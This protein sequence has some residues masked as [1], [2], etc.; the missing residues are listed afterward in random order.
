MHT[1][2]WSASNLLDIKDRGP[3]L[4]L[5]RKL[6]LLLRLLIAT[7]H[8]FLDLFLV[9]HGNFLRD[10]LATTDLGFLL[11]F[12]NLLG[13]DLIIFRF[14]VVIILELLL[15]PNSSSGLISACISL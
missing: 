9:I 2:T 5:N 13:S 14:M 10:L 6:L 11:L 12:F 7:E 15:L 8:V 3:V 4:F 1:I